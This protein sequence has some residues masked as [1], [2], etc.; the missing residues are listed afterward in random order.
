M[1]REKRA[2]GCAELSALSFDELKDSVPSILGCSSEILVLPVEEAVRRTRVDDDLVLDTCCVE[3]RVEGIDI[4]DRDPRV[5]SA[6]EGEER[7]C[8]LRRAG[9]RS[10]RAVASRPR[11]SVEAD[12][13]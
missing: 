2:L 8:K 3:R 1:L 12:R 7:S 6:H 13:A 5:I 11:S 9:G 4:L 10:R